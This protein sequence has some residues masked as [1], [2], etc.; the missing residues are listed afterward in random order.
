[1]SDTLA[2]AQV[3][4]VDEVAVGQQHGVQLLVSFNAGGHL[5]QHVRPVIVVC[6]AT[7]AFRLALHSSPSQNGIQSS[8]RH[9]EIKI[10]QKM[11]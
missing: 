3:A 4:T 5:G 8:V 10:S 2:A 1:M 9:H 6:D 11:P 7:E